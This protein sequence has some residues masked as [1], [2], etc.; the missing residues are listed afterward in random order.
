MLRKNTSFELEYFRDETSLMPCLEK[1]K[2]KY[3][4]FIGSCR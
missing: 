4:A 2:K 3:R 1:I